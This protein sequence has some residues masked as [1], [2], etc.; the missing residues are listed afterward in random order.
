MSLNAKKSQTKFFLTLNLS[1]PTLLRNHS[2]AFSLCMTIKEKYPRPSVAEQLKF[3]F[4]SY[5]LELLESHP[6]RCNSLVL[7]KGFGYLCKTTSR[8]NL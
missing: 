7:L 2:L 1:L 4:R 5:T 6:V 3:F 8:K